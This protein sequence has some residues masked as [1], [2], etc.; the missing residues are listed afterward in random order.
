MIKIHPWLLKLQAE[1]PRRLRDEITFS[2]IGSPW[3]TWVRGQ[4]RFP[5][6]CPLLGRPQPSPDPP[7]AGLAGF[8][9]PRPPD[10][11]HPS[12][13]RFA[14][15]YTTPLEARPHPH[16]RPVPG[17]APPTLGPAFPGRATPPAPP[18]HAPA[19]P[20]QAPPP[21]PGPAHAAVRALPE[22]PSTCSGAGGQLPGCP[23]APW[24]RPS[25]EVPLARPPR[26][27]VERG[28]RREP[29][30]SAARVSARPARPGTRSDA[31][32][33]RP[34]VWWP[35]LSNRRPSAERD[36]TGT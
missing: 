7:G 13:A 24:E 34:P 8:F 10:R 33:R 6:V 2:F 26:S 23:R 29:G 4:K 28:I 5:T 1:S 11:P 21:R 14:Q 31:F 32:R 17:K 3:Y 15:A 30:T 36:R 22:L 19:P 20:D 12:R 9:R 27:R 18:H 25:F 16:C 35:G